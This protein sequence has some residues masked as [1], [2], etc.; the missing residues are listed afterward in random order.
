MSH[1]LPR[2]AST[3][4]GRGAL[5]EQARSALARQ[6]GVLTLEGPGGV[7]KT[8]LA[9]EVAS[10]W[11][12]P[13]W[14]IDLHTVRDAGALVLA[15]CR[16]LGLDGR[17]GPEAVDEQLRALG[18]ALV[19]LDNA[20][21]L[22]AASVA[23]VQGWADAAHPIRW[24]VTSRRRLS[25]RGERALSVPTLPVPTT[26][27]AVP[28]SE[29]AHVFLDA[30]APWTPS[31]AELPLLCELLALLDGLPLA[32]QLAASRLEIMSLAQLLRRL[33]QQPLDTLR[34][35]EHRGERH[36]SLS[37]ALLWSWEMLSEEEQ[38]ALL[39]CTAFAAPF[40][41]EAAEAV[42]A[43]VIAPEQVLDLL[44]RLRRRHLLLSDGG[45]FRMLET[46]R[47]FCCARRSP[48]QHAPVAQAHAAWFAAKARAW[49]TGSR[50]A[51]RVEMM[52][53]IEAAFDEL[54]ALLQRAT[55]PE[56]ALEAIKA[57]VAV[58]DI[59]GPQAARLAL[60][61]SALER[62]GDLEDPRWL[63]L[64]IRRT[65]WLRQKGQ[66][67]AATAALEAAARRAESSGDLSLRAA[68]LDEQGVYLM[69]QTGAFERNRRALLSA[70]RQLKE[71]ILEST[72][73][74]G[75]ALVAHDQNR[76][77]EADRLIQ[78]ARGCAAQVGD[79]PTIANTLSQHVTISLERGDAA[80]PQLLAEAMAAYQQLGDE[81]R[82]G[83]LEGNLGLFLE[84][85]G[86][87]EPAKPHYVDA[88]ARLKGCGDVLFA[89]YYEG[90]LGRTL[91]LL[92]ERDRA[93]AMLEQAVH[94]MTA[95]DA[96]LL[97]ALN[98]AR[99]IE[100]ALA[101]DPEALLPVQA[102]PDNHYAMLAPL[103]SEVARLLA[104]DRRRASRRPEA[105]QQLA[106]IRSRCQHILAEVPRAGSTGALMAALLESAERTL[107]GWRVD[108]LRGRCLTPDGALVDISRSRAQSAVMAALAR[109][110]IHTPGRPCSVAV[111][112]EAGWPGEQMS[113]TSAANRVRVALSGLRRAGLG[114]LLRRGPGGWF[115]DPDVE[116]VIEA[117]TS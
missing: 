24:L 12:G 90:F 21:Q 43:A 9:V 91:L 47:A 84:Q 13:A 57:L 117:L 97:V 22:D 42:L 74:A 35:P 100:R 1:S 46:V 50:G 115:F 60:L 87:L 26:A 25:V 62:F 56:H 17:R 71:P 23:C 28:D 36:D 94:R 64:E 14:F 106:E 30:A 55:A 44:H 15:L 27:A 110:R 92:G 32:L 103:V 10:G 3:L 49:R 107:S 68:V 102:S 40:S 114:A 5:L 104:E 16:T 58:L 112:Q 33:R 7:G 45:R 116:V 11:S 79:L 41:L 52:E 85:S 76:P 113:A 101:A 82:V 20:E 108:A 89:A 31:A 83:I 6:G 54:E 93:R 59:R 78:Q 65:A 2:Y 77:G 95:G 88:I 38:R 37:D 73:L 51:R 18:A 111:L 99:N 39:G 75:L 8:R 29:A 67:D 96:R 4:R 70:A 86:Q 80:T 61:E 19:V 98:F 72:A 53:R 109:A 48:D 34:T 66:L 69:S 81:R 63:Y 105:R